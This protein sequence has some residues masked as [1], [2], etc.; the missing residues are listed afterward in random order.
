MLKAASKK[1]GNKIKTAAATRTPAR[2]VQA[3][4]AANGNAGVTGSYI[5]DRAL[6]K[7]VKVSSDIPKVASQGVSES[8]PEASSPCGPEACGGG[9]CMPGGLD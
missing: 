7:V 2:A 8:A 9:G 4:M 6:G 1:N 5:F 3:A